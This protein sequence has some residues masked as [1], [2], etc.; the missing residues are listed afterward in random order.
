MI[1]IKRKKLTK[2]GNSFYFHV[3]KKYI[4]DK[5]LLLEKEYNLKINES[6]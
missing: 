3:P 4:D 1:N 6:N 5:N 2:V